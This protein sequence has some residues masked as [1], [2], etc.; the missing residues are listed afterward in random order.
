MSNEPLNRLYTDAASF[1]FDRLRIVPLVATSD[2]T[3]YNAKRFEIFVENETDGTLEKFTIANSACTLSFFE[4]L[5]KAVAT[6]MARI[7]PLYGSASYPRYQE[8]DGQLLEGGVKHSEQTVT[9]TT[10][11]ENDGA[12]S[13]GVWRVNPDKVKP[14]PH[15]LPDRFIGG[16]KYSK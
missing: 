10:A 16:K 12:Q 14:L 2:A 5:R 11:A 9:D 3:R 8:E 4:N 15:A 6:E 7:E 1:P 13:T